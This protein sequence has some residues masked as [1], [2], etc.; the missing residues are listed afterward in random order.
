[1]QKDVLIK[2][3]ISRTFA[4]DSFLDSHRIDL[5]NLVSDDVDCPSSTVDNNN[6]VT[7]LCQS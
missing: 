2:D 7:D 6:G 3:N 1:M 5:D 4:C